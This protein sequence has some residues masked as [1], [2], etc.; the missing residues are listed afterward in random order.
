M[1]GDVVGKIDCSRLP[2]DLELVLFYPVA[3][4]IE[5]HVNGFGALLLDSVIDDALGARIVGFDWCWRL[6]VA[7]VLE[8]LA[9]W[10]C[11]LGVDVGSAYFSF[12]G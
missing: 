11:F 4:P 9:K 2:I 8:R 3:K 1:L 12:C 7:H 5:S 10:T 6:V